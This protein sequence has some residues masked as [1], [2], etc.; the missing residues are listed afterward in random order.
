MIRAVSAVAMIYEF[1]DLD[2]PACRAITLVVFLLST[3][4]QLSCQQKSRNI[5]MPDF[6][7]GRTVNFSPYTRLNFVSLA[8][9]EEM[10]ISYRL[11][12]IYS[13]QTRSTWSSD[14][15]EIEASTP[16]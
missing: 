10:S 3:T 14:Q 9:L 6:S 16:T 5:E 7:R 12:N 4:P 8:T 15:D 13:I 1:Q 2:D 11:G